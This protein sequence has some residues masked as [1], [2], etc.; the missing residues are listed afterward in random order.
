MYNQCV[1]AEG[2]CLRN[3]PPLSFDSM[4]EVEA[5]VFIIVPKFNHVEFGIGGLG[6]SED[7]SGDRGRMIL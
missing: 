1:F 2:N 7:G 3:I 4:L 6:R 5:Q